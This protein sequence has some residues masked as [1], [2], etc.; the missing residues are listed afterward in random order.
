MRVP[1]YS[2][3][4]EQ[5]ALGSALLMREAAETMME[6]LIEHHGIQLHHSR[7]CT[8]APGGASPAPA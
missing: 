4:A 5:A 3:D 1:P 2:L 8:G 7:R 6:L